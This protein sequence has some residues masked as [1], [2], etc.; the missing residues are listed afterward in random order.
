MGH[1]ALQRVSMRM[2]YDPR[3]AEQVY[4][5]PSA[6]LASVDI[7]ETERQWLLDVDPRAWTVDSQ[8][9]Q[10][11]LRNLFGE[12]RG[13]TTLALAQTRSLSGL[14]AFFQS[15]HF[16]QQVQQR[17]SLAR[18]YARFLGE[19]TEDPLV[20][21]VARLE[22]MQAQC[23]RELELCPRLDSLAPK[24]IARAPGIGAGRFDGATLD[25]LN[26]AE[27]ALFQLQLI[28][29]AGLCDDAPRPS[30]VAPRPDQPLD[31]IA[32]PIDGQIQLVQLGSMASRTLA[33][34]GSP[35]T[36]EAA[37]ARVTSLGLSAQRGAALLGG[38]LGEGLL[39]L[40][41]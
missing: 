40:G 2:L 4:A 37:V 1:Q 29:A 38:L 28:P 9:G 41:S 5:D 21:E 22:W 27:Q 16:H 25:A 7:T 20:A 31:L 10:R 8:R 15:P 34:L 14:Q 6:T 18:G 26:A 30:P 32:R 17:G 33:L 24:A 39:I 23:R 36:Q 12:F 19:L 35:H 13:S 3:F 11:C